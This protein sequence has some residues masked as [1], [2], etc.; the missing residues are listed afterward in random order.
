MKKGLL[1][2][3][4]IAA[5]FSLSFNDRFKESVHGLMEDNIFSKLYPL[6]P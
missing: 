2:T 5:I 4:V 1:M 6:S 3:S